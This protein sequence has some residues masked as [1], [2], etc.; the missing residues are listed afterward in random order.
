MIDELSLDEVGKILQWLGLDLRCQ[1]SFEMAHKTAVKATMRRGKVSSPLFE[2]HVLQDSL[3]QTNGGFSVLHEL[4]F[5]LFDVQTGQNQLWL[6]AAIDI[7]ERR[8]N[9]NERRGDLP[10]LFLLGGRSGLETDSLIS[11]L[12]FHCSNVVQNAIS[13]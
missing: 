11:F 5:G 13:A 10:S 4:V 7:S 9:E 2:T 6:L 8:R 3:H 1:L 12:P